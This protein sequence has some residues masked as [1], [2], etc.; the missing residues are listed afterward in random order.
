MEEP[1]HSSDDL[2][3][4]LPP[5]RQALLDGFKNY[6][7]LHPRLV[8]VQMQVLDTIW[9]P[10]DVTHVVVCGPSGVGK[11]KLAE[12]LARRL[13]A[14]KSASNGHS[15][16]WAL[17]VNTRPP[18]GELFH[19]TS[20]YKKGLALLGKTTFDLHIKV[21]VA[22]A[23][24]L[25]EK[26]R[27]KGKT[28]RYPDDP[29]IR[30]VYEEEL[31]RL[32]LRAVLLD[33]AQHLITSGDDKQP[34]DQLNWI[35]SMSTETGV[36]HVLIGTYGLLPFCNLDGQMARRGSEFHFAPYHIE[37]ENDCQ[38]FRSAFSSLLKRLPLQ[39]DHD[40]LIQRWWYFFE[41]S[42]GC[43]GILKQWMVR[44][45]YRALREESSELTR[46]HLEKSVLPD[47]KWERM[48]ADA[49]SGEA[50]FRYADG[51]NSYLS[52]LASMPTFAPSRLDPASPPPSTPSPEDGTA[53]QKKSKPKRRVGEPSPRRDQVGTAQQEEETTHCSFSGPIKLEAV[54][55][56]ESS[57]QAVQCTTCGSVSK[58]KLKEQSVV[59]SPHPPRK[60]RA[61]RNITRWMEVGMEWVLVQKKE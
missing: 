39:T 21:D 26:K 35:K 14:P 9:E 18:D 43:I 25:V 38:A 52:D 51:Q 33:E 7:V 29:D 44:A 11:S 57:V 12:I 30:E 1:L 10:A 32:T 45:L 16:R 28:T 48:R 20:F 37:D 13:N 42:I 47:A 54:R 46:T 4:P 15:P 49:R 56:L 40:A 6:S 34:K 2:F 60:V 8:Q 17:L 19:R 3:E 23:E 31:R 41:G 58:A 53:E 50:E 27:A 36:L 61:V 59:I 22:T 5:E 55:W 24:H